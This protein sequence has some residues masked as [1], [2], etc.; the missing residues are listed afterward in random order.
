[1]AAHE[2]YAVRRLIQ[3]SSG[4]VNGDRSLYWFLG[5]MD[6]FDYVWTKLIQ[7]EVRPGGM[8]L[9]WKNIIPCNFRKFYLR[10]V[11]QGGGTLKYW[12]QCFK[13]HFWLKSY[14]Y[15]Y[16]SLLPTSWKCFDEMQTELDMISLRNWIMLLCALY[17]S[18]RPYQQKVVSSCKIRTFMKLENIVILLSIENTFKNHLKKNMMITWFNSFYIY[19]WTKCFV[20]IREFHSAYIL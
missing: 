10:D 20:R 6:E 3:S 14:P 1:M 5:W 13:I 16:L 7:Y 19:F 2:F 4:L 15:I 18:H 11:V 8:N 17:Q 9:I 12:A